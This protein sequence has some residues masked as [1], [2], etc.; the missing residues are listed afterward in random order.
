MP[1]LL[2]VTAALPDEYTI[3]PRSA[4]TFSKTEGAGLQG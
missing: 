1:Q 3:E 4:A 2:T